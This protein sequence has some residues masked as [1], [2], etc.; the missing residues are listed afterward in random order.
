MAFGGGLDIPFHKH[1][2]FRPVEIDY[3]LT[4]FDNPFTG[5]KNQNNFRYATGLVF[6]FGHTY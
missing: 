1:V 3:L 4:R 2:S 6:T 5:H